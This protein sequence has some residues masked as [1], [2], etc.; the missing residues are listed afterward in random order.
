MLKCCF[1]NEHLLFFCGRRLPFKVPR[2][3]E[4]NRKRNVETQPIVD[5]NSIVVFF[6]FCWSRRKFSFF[7][8]KRLRMRGFSIDE[9]KLQHPPHFCVVWFGS[10]I[11]HISSLV[12]PPRAILL[13]I[14]ACFNVVHH[15]RKLTRYKSTINNGH[16]LKKKGT[17][18][19]WQWE[20]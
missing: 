19:V 14:L 15:L 17:H 6:F 5:F 11:F 9:I 1:D 2:T 7:S 20:K 4:S 3:G 10:T 12:C 8:F 18:S 13:V 16:Y